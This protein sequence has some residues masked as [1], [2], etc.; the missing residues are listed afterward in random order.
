M[1]DRL[2]LVAHRVIRNSSKVNDCIDAFKTIIGNVA[3][4]SEILAR[5]YTLGRIHRT[6]KRMS[7]EC[8]VIA[9]NLRIGMCIAQ[10][11]TDARPDVALVTCDE[12]FQ[13]SY[14]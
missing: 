3:D 5:Q 11:A 6:R 12:N 9:P 10:I 1:S 2:V 4:I 7:E 8:S 14:R 13:A